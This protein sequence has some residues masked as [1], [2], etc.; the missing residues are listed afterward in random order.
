MLC[1]G[2][3]LKFVSDGQEETR[4]QVT[5]PRFRYL[6]EAGVSSLAETEG[7]PLIALMHVKSVDELR[8]GGEADAVYISHTDT[9]RSRD[10]H[11]SKVLGPIGKFGK[12]SLRVW[13]KLLTV[14]CQRHSFAVLLKQRDSQFLFQLAE[15]IAQAWLRY[16]QQ[17]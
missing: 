7:Y 14:F 16:V 5:P 6:A 2:G 13:Q 1:Q 11:L 12:S 4:F 9:S 8:E 10:F 3:L 17:P 15:R